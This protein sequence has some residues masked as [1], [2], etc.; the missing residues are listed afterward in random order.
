MQS[1][2][3]VFPTAK[4]FSVYVDKDAA[5][6]S[7][8]RRENYL[9]LAWNYLLNR[10]HRFLEHNCDNAPG[11]VISDDSASS[12]IR[13]LMRKMR[14]YNPLPSHYDPR[15]FY[16]APVRT[17]IE[18]PFFRESQHSYFVQIA[19]IISHSLY[20]KLYVKG[21]YRRYNLHKFYDY[22]DPII[23]KTATSK[24][25]LNMGIVRIP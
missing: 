2:V 18:D 25:P 7:N 4:T 16:N 1:L 13:S 23:L 11:V 5:F 20:R 12:T 22:L 10:Y 19:D 6:Q 24:D 15:G 9:T 21:S 17:I 3:G 8:Y 14:V